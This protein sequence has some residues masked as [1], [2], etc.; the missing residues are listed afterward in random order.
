[1]NKRT[2]LI[3]KVA[4]A[5]EDVNLLQQEVRSYNINPII[6]E[7][8]DFSAR[9]FYMFLKE[10]FNSTII[11]HFDRNVLDTNFRFGAV[12]KAAL[13]GMIHWHEGALSDTINF[14]GRIIMTG[15]HDDMPAALKDRCIFAS[16]VSAS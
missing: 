12:I 5:C 2:G 11:L 16:L 14:T 3:V 1:M 4:D 8:E 15:H 7:A 9:D 13:D 10:N 6:V